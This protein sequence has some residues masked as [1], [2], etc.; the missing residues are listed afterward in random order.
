MIELPTE[1]AQISRSSIELCI[2]MQPAILP[3]QIIRI[4]QLVI[5]CVPGGIFLIHRH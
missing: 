2:S 1:F 4:G 5:L 3:I